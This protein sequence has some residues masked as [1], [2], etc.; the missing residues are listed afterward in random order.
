MRSKNQDSDEKM[1]KSI[2]ELKTIL[3]SITDQINT[4]KYSQS[5]KDSPKPPDPTSVVP[6]K[7]RAPPL[8]GL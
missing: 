3:A 1:T 2:E 6:D 5:K 8:D 7:R 4:L